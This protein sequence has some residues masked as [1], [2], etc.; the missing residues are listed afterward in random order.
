MKKLVWEKNKK[1]EFYGN[2]DNKQLNYLFELLDKARTSTYDLHAKILAKLYGNLLKNRELNYFESDLLS[3]IDFLND[4]DIESI[5]KFLSIECESL[6][7][8]RDKTTIKDCNQIIFK[9]D[10]VKEQRIFEKCLLIGIISIEDA[11]GFSSNNSPL[12]TN[13][14][15]YFTEYSLEFY[16][17]LDEVLNEKL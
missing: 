13:K 4:D 11:F 16:K 10:S 2:I 8:I 9:I 7:D 17:I 14:D 15:C 3:H 1:K 12:Y 5:Y 6:N